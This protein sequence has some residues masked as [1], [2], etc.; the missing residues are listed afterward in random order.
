VKAL[1]FPLSDNLERIAVH[2]EIGDDPFEPAILIIERTHLGDVANLKATALGLP[3][4]ERL[5]ADTVFAAQYFRIAPASDSL[6]MPTICVLVKPGFLKAH[7]FRGLSV[8]ISASRNG[9]P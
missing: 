1:E 7:S 2:G 3:L 5:R 4:V 9:L 6:M 8:R